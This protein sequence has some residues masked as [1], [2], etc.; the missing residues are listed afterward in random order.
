MPMF[1][2]F[3]FRVKDPDV[4]AALYADLL[5]GEVKNI[6]GPPDTI[7]AKGVVFGNHAREIMADLVE[8]W[9][10]DKRWTPQGFVDVDPG[11]AMFGHLAIRSDMSPE[12]LAAIAKKHGVTLAMEER[13]VG[14]PVP[15]VYDYDGNFIEVFR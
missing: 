4:S 12:N 11:G 13:G 7:G 8:F 6:G 9:P 2:H 10:A 14:Y 5:Q 3:A 1:L 15:V